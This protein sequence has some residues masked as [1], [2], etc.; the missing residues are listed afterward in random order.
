MPNNGGFFKI[1]KNKIKIK[2]ATYNKW[3]F[4]VLSL[5]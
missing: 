1:L 4:F 3:P 5:L 2:K